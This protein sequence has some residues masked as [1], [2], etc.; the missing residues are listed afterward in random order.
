MSQHVSTVCFFLLLN[1]I[2]LYGHILS[3]HLPVDGQLGCLQSW[4]LLNTADLNISI[5]VFVWTYVF[6]SLRYIPGVELLG[7]MVTIY[8]T[9]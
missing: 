1:S 4:Q 8:L 5:Q 3:I 6:I 9:F 2:P 7:H